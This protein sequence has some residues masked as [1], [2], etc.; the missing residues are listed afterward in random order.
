MIIMDPI[1]LLARPALLTLWLAGFGA[2][3]PHEEPEPHPSRFAPRDL[4]SEKSLYGSDG[5]RQII[6]QIQFELCH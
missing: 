3:I 6:F 2:C 1:D 5:E 4:V